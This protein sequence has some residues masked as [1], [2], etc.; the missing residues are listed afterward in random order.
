VRAALAAGRETGAATALVTSNPNP[1]LR[2]LTEFVIVADTG[3]EAITG[4]TR[5]KAGTAA[6]LVLHTFSTALMVRLGH[7]Y[8]HFMVDMQETNAKLRGRSVGMLV[9]ATGESEQRCVEALERCGDRKV[10]LVFLLSARGNGAVS[11]EACRE[12]LTR[13]GGR[14]REALAVLR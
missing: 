8:G 10:A 13:A 4:S 7:T 2:D 5:M 1:A 14:V 6:K 9:Q 11:P 3:P 12:A